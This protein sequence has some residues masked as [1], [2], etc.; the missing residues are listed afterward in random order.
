[1]KLAVNYSPQAAELLQTGQ[2]KFD[3]FKT[4]NWHSM[5]EEASTYLPVYVHFDL[6]VGDGSLDAIDWG[7]VQAFLD[8]TNT[9]IVNLHVITPPDLDPCSPVLVNETL[10][11]IV[12]EVLGVTK[13]F[14]SDKVITENVPLPEKG[15]KY[16]RPVV[17][18]AFFQRLSAETGCGML[19]D[20]AHA[21][22]TAKS[23]QTDPYKFFSEFPVRRL[24]EIHITGLGMHDGEIHDH[25]EMTDRDWQYFEWALAKIHLGD[26]HTPEIIAF[27][28]GGTG[29]PF[30]WRSESRVLLSQVPRFHQLIHNG[31]GKNA[32]G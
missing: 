18:P 12:S 24:K 21:A 20:L 16:L 32:S 4:P 10:D 11:R 2:I 7:E 26:W 15:R 5:V 30:I 13:R 28:Y 14:G 29:I 19:L 17:T 6:S 1:M 9:S 31:N 8:K 23:L 25:L 22:I 3:L 27:E